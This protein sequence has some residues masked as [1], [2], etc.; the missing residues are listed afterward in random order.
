MGL[1]DAV[2]FAVT[3]PLNVWMDPPPADAPP[4]ALQP[5]AH[6]DIRLALKD[7]AFVR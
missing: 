4:G 1:Q 3:P 6:V 2:N 7:G 5:P